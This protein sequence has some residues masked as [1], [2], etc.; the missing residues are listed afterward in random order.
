MSSK[1]NFS[2]EEWG[3]VI[4]A[5]LVAGFAVTAA[6]PGGLIGAFQESA[7]VAKAMTNAKQSAAEGSLLAE[8]VSAFE[9]SE[10]RGIARQGVR[11]LTKGNTPAEACDAA[12]VRLRE[13]SGL[14]RTKTPDE[15]DAFNN[16]LAGIAES[17]AEAAKEGGFMGF[18]G[19]PVSDAEHK[20]LAD[21]NTA[22]TG[23]VA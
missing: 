13:I 9:T 15:S 5:P 19:E 2:D 14:V 6:D 1:D 17:V 8:A 7:A 12:I 22:L 3:L 4:Q 16:W 11:E 23:A 10:A 20:A 21:I 18:G